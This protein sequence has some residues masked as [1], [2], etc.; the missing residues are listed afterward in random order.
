MGPLIK[1]QRLLARGGASYLALRQWR[2]GLKPCQLEAFRA[3]KQFEDE[4]F[5][6][7]VTKELKDAVVK[8]YGKLFEAIVPIPGG[9]S[10]NARSFSVGYRLN[11]TCCNNEKPRACGLRAFQNKFLN[12]VDQ[13][14]NLCST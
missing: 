12:Q 6:D 8:V 1:K 2:K 3:L 13:A 14:L 11:H 4:L 5:E 7:L 9:S 10:G